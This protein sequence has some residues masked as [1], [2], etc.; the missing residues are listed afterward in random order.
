MSMSAPPSPFGSVLTAMITPFSPDGALDV[1]R[2]IQVAR[3]LVES[4]NDGLVIAGSTG[5]SAMLSDD[6]RITMWREIVNA[7][8]VP[9]IAGSTTGDTRHSLELTREAEAAGVAGILATT[10][11]YSRPSQ[12]GI[13]QHFEAIA[14]VTTLP[15]VLYDI[16]SRTG[17]RLSAETILSVALS[18]SNVIG[19]K[20]AAGDVVASARLMASAP[21][22][23]ALYSGDD[24]LTLPL[25]A[26]GACGVIGVATHWCGP[27]MKEMISAF[28]SGDIARAI[29]INQ[30]MLPSFAFESSDEAPNP[31]PSKAVLRARG[32]PVGQCRLPL[33]DAPA[34]LDDAARELLG[35][36]DEWR[37][38][39]A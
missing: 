26:I 9:V 31:L 28:F 24:S 2:A 37:A 18:R 21:A 6:E 33:G 39:R 19:L 29:S 4:G 16:P 22:G 7:V 15:V 20:D 17:R 13:A 35:A 8:S 11:Y 38:S 12:H 27:E 1:E 34:A 23:F 32:L 25:L 36:L 14:A 5:E 10:P 30:A 3:A